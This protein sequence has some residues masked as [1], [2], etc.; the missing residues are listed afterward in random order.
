MWCVVWDGNMFS[1]FYGVVIC[2][3]WGGSLSSV[4]CGVVN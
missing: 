2:V 1:V 3:V 4:L